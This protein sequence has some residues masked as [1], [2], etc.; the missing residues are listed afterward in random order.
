MATQVH[1]E[2]CAKKRKTCQWLWTNS[3]IS[4]TL[5]F[6]CVLETHGNLS[7]NTSTNLPIP[8]EHD[9][10][11]LAYITTWFNKKSYTF[12]S[13]KKNL[14][15]QRIVPSKCLPETYKFRHVWIWNGFGWYRC[16]RALFIWSAK[17]CIFHCHFNNHRHI[18][19]G[20]ARVF[21]HTKSLQTESSLCR[22][23]FSSQ[24]DKFSMV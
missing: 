4:R 10:T 12:S 14:T 21:L 5:F 23:F 2:F 20:P 11:S 3:A 19:D 15:L 9:V 18:N 16:S 6:S 8:W 17:C 13:K 1:R 22:I 7:C 24:Q